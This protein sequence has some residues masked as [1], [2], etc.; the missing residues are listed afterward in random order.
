MLNF[1]AIVYLTNLTLSETTK[2]GILASWPIL[3]YISMFNHYRGG[4]KYSVERYGPGTGTSFLK[5]MNCTGPEWKIDQCPSPVNW[6]A[7]DCP[8]SL[9]VGV[10]C[11][12]GSASK[13]GK[14]K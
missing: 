5:N 4:D 8:H 7:S 6:D 12:L 9:D 11:K 1:M 14:W 13:E 2:T 10:S 3:R